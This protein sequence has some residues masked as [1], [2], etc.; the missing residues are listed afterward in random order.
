MADDLQTIL[1]KA[2]IAECINRYCRGVDRLDSD[3][4]KSAYHPDGYDDHGD[5]KGSVD[6]FV[7]ELVPLLR[8]NYLS[9]SHNICN[10]LVELDGERAFVESY[11]IAVHVTETAGTQYQEIIFGRYVD[12][13]EKRG[14]DWRIVHRVCV[15][16]SR[17]TKPV[18]A[19][20]LATDETKIPRG[21]R[22]ET[23]AVYTI[24][25]ALTT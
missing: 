12:R 24:R 16:D 11:L 18:E 23:D 22:D 9:T 17:N 6:E 7:A 5:L 3:L 21:R 1:D 19:S 8:S 15:I 13:F 25:A 2:A 10:Q 20:R 4:I 14:A